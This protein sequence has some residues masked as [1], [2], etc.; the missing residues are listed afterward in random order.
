MKYFVILI[1]L[2]AVVLPLT[3]EESS[4]IIKMAD[5]DRSFEGFSFS[6]G[7]LIKLDPAEGSFPMEIDF[8]FDMP[9]GLGM[10][11]SELTEWF[12][13]RAGIIDLGPVSLESDTE[14]SVEGFNP[15]LDPESIISGHTYLILTADTEHFG[16][17]HIINFD[18]ESE[19]VE[20]TWI[21]LVE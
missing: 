21:Y 4:E 1:M 12:P 6:N 16:K 13:G 19:L 9:S 7:E 18:S 11:N 8:I 14:L 20:F 17:I 3:A 5:F 10:N 15:F 2:I